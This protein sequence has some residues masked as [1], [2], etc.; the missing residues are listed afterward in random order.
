MVRA[1]SFYILEG[2]TLMAQVQCF[3]PQ[4]GAAL[5]LKTFD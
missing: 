2:A 5:R 1:L 3:E 4:R